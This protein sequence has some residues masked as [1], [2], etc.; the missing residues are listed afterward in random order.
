[1]MR[2]F[3]ESRAAS[4][5]LERGLDVLL[6][7]KRFGQ[8]GRIVRRLGNAGRH[9]RPRDEGRIAHDRDPAK[10]HAR[11]F[12][13]VD[14]LQDRLFDQPHDLPELGRDAGVRRRRASR[15]SPRGGS[16]G[17]GIEIACVTPR[18]SVSSHCSLVASSAGP[19]PDDIV[20]AIAGPQ[21][22]V[23]PRHRIAE[24]LFAR[25]Q[26]E[27]HEFEKLAMHVRGKTRSAISARQAL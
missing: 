10:C 24:K 17:G 22:I 2:W 11:R 25:R 26:A 9:M 21:I 20:A 13:I 12:Q 19:I 4:I 15:R 8:R 5:A 23:G 14:R 18:S 3:S 27:R 7:L 16:S 1:M 6:F